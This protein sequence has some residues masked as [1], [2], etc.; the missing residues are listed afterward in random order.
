MKKLLLIL[1]I[2]PIMF[3]ACKKDEEDNRTNGF[4]IGETEYELDNGTAV[5]FGVTV[6]NGD[7][8]FDVY[9]FSSEID[10]NSTTGVG[11]RIYFELFSETAE[12]IKSGTYTFNA[13]QSG[14]AGTFGSGIKDIITVDYDILR[15]SGTSY[16]VNGGTL[17]VSVSGNT[18]TFDFSLQLEDNSTVTGY[19]KGELTKIDF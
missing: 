2:A 14:T 18:Y 15:D 16:N 1:L 12:D 10:Y 3:S 4:T 19:Y 17:I 11:E 7:I 13:N 5:Y 8:N 9:L 6:E